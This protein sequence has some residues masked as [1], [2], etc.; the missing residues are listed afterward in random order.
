MTNTVSGVPDNI[1]VYRL[2]DTRQI[3]F[4]ICL[5]IGLK[6]KIEIGHITDVHIN[7]CLNET[8]EESEVNYTKKCR[9]WLANGESLN[10]LD[11]AMDV[12][13]HCDQ[14]VIT[15]DI[16]DYLSNGA[17]GLVKKHIFERNPEIICTLGGHD[18]TKQVQTKRTN[19][20]SIEQRFDILREIWIHD[21]F[22]YSKIIKNEII[23]VGLNNCLGKYYSMQIDNLKSDI[24]K[25]RKENK[26]IMI[27][28]HEPISTQKVEDKNKPPDY[29]ASPSTSMIRNFYDGCMASPNCKDSA[30]K[31][32]YNLIINNADII[33]GVFC[34]HYHS[35]FYTEI[36]PNKKNN[37]IETI[38]QIVSM[39][40]PYL[41]N[42]GV[43][44]RIIVC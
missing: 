8:L 38:P 14:T 41:G 6:E 31:E 7:Y 4:E 42:S 18:I 29:A 23:V 25:A 30:T 3:I 16:L 9:T 10:A 44:T 1:K 37:P 27:F 43:V 33:K 19:L 17:I 36:K 20:M 15:G 32:I 11:K 40:N 28:Q 22:Y 2:K 39:G 13:E 5:N 12:C 24:K 35:F 34:G 26:Y 21:I